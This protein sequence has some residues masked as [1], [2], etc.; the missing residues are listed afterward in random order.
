MEY[1][2]KPLFNYA[3]TVYDRC[4]R[5]AI[6]EPKLSYYALTMTCPA[7]KKV[8]KKAFS[9]LS[10]SEQC[11]FYRKFLDDNKCEYIITFEE[12]DKGHYHAHILLHYGCDDYLDHLGQQ[13]MKYVGIKTYKQL[14][15]LFKYQQV[16]SERDY[17][18]WLNYIFKE[19]P[20]HYGLLTENEENIL[21]I[22]Y[23]NYKNRSNNYKVDINPLFDIIN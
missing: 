6:Y 12:H 5:Q 17:I 15:D 22:Y 18:N 10:Y 1:R 14:N 2:Q 13:Y 21:E 7:F 20:E 23:Q 19:H 4:N 9:K 3:E 16:I 8:N 11:K